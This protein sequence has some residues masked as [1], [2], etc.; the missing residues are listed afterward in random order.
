MWGSSWSRP[1]DP[2]QP[3]VALEHQ[4]FGAGLRFGA[5]SAA[6]GR[7]FF[8][9]S[10]ECALLQQ[11]DDFKGVSEALG[12]FN[13][14]TKPLSMGT[15][16]FSVVILVVLP[17]NLFDHRSFQTLHLFN[18]GIVWHLAASP[19]TQRAR[20]RRGWALSLEHV[21]EACSWPIVMRRSAK[22][23]SAAS[24]P[25]LAEISRRLWNLLLQ[26]PRLLGFFRQFAGE[27]AF[28]FG[29]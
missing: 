20:V 19:P 13:G 23:P 26:E 12:H 11:P 16:A 1:R 2:R 29:V 27:H 15:Y 14:G 25:C 5:A 8:L 28:A 4:S 6:S 3:Q 18:H 24:L 22:S 17:T 10:P 9:P 7:V 21:P